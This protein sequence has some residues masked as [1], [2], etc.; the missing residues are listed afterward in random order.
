ME[1][2]QAKD[3]L[4]VLNAEAAKFMTQEQLNQAIDSMTDEKVQ[5]AAKLQEAM[6]SLTQEDLAYWAEAFLHQIAN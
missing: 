2:Q 4:K 3:K 6:D 5:E 1:I